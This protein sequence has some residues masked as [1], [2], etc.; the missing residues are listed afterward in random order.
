MQN[1]NIPYYLGG[2]LLSHTHVMPILGPALCF[3]KSGRVHEW[4]GHFISHTYAG[5]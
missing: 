2:P 4:S 3:A 1:F 5:H